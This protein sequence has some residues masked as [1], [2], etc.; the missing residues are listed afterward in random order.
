M[1]NAHAGTLSADQLDLA[2]I[3]DA[4][5]AMPPA[6]KAGIAAMVKAASAK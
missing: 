3:I 6:L 5:P 2:I 1:E 4:W